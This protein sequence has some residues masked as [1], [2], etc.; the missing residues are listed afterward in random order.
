[1]AIHSRGKNVFIYFLQV[2]LATCVCSSQAQNEVRR[3]PFLSSHRICKKYEG[4]PAFDVDGGTTRINCPWVVKLS[5][6]DN[7]T[8]IERFRRVL[9]EA[10]KLTDLRAVNLPP[11]VDCGRFE[12]RVTADLRT[13]NCRADL[14]E[15]VPHLFVADSSGRI[16]RMEISVNYKNIYRAAL[17]KAI[18]RGSISKFYEPYVDLQTD[19]MVEKL[20]F[21]ASSLDTVSVDGEQLSV[22]LSVRK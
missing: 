12:E 11:G 3:L 5:V 6:L 21:I 19:L 14:G 2:V 9:D 8:L 4:Q 10:P 17:S 1:M 7:Q 13:I 22:V 15:T 20:R 16:L 18:A